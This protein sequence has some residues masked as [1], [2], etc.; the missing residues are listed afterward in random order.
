MDI[1]V[2]PSLPLCPQPKKPLRYITKYL[3]SI[4]PTPRLYIYTL[5]TAHKNPGS[6]PVCF[7]LFIPRN[8]V[9]VIHKLLKARAL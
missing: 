9:C 6:T 3:Y 1:P 4:K 5:V 2:F 7:V 8:A